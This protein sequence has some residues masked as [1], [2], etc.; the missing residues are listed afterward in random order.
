MEFETVGVPYFEICA[1]SSCKSGHSSEK[2]DLSPVIP[3]TIPLCLL[4][5]RLLKIFQKVNC[6]SLV[7][8]LIKIQKSHHLA[9]ENHIL[10]NLTNVGT[11]D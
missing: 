1:P 5:C 3:Q 9:L 7:I 4:N 8:I 10:G 6:S 2:L 11:F